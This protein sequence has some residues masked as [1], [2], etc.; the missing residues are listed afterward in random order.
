MTELTLLA[1]IASSISRCEE[2]PLWTHKSAL[3]TLLQAI[4]HLNYAIRKH[5]LDCTRIQSS[6]YVNQTLLASLNKLKAQ[7][8]SIQVP[9]NIIGDLQ[10]QGVIPLID[11]SGRSLVTTFIWVDQLL[12][13]FENFYDSPTACTILSYMVRAEKTNFRSEFLVVG[14]ENLMKE[15]KTSQEK[16]IPQQSNYRGFFTHL[17]EPVHM[18]TGLVPLRS[19]H[20]WKDHLRTMHEHFEDPKTVLTPHYNGLKNVSSATQMLSL[21]TEI[22]TIHKNYGIAR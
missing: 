10:V 17:R 15:I 7:Y 9:F 3:F 11:R 12:S 16:N 14:D 1:T 4:P 20:L 8:S 5:L 21:Y 6:Q 13:L 2:D 18:E 22:Q 19:I